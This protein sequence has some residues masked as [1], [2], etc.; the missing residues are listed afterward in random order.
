MNYTR[1]FLHLSLLLI[2]IYT[3]HLF[4]KLVKRKFQR[5]KS[6]DHLTVVV[7]SN[8]DLNYR[9]P[10][11]VSIRSNIRKVPS[12]I[13]P[14]F[15]RMVAIGLSGQENAQ[16]NGKFLPDPSGVCFF[17]SIHPNR[18][19]FFLLERLPGKLRSSRGM[20]KRCLVI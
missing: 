14:G 9:G 3:V 17:V 11:P 6:S 8:R 13:L 16:P 4:G 7:K 10:V 12:A 5:K 19:I 2:S 18:P 20:G 15:G 1:R